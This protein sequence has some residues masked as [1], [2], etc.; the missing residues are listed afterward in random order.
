MGPQRPPYP[1]SV[2]CLSLLQFYETGEICPIF[3]MGSQPI[4]VSLGSKTML[5]YIVR[6]RGCLLYEWKEG[7]EGKKISP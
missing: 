4:S 5:E 3:P 6:T 1:G 7:K 2:S